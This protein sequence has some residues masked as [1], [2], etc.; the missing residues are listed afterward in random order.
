VKAE[1]ALKECLNQI[2]EVLEGNVLADPDCGDIEHERLEEEECP[3]IHD[4]CLYTLRMVNDADGY[5]KAMS[6][7]ENLMKMDMPKYYAGSRWLAMLAAVVEAF[8][9]ENYPLDT[10]ENP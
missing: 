1:A 10:E 2:Q 9:I 5:D 4:L 6:E 3:H 8:E 7:I